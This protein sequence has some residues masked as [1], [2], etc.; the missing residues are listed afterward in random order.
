MSD[1]ETKDQTEADD[2]IEELKRQVAAMEDDVQKSNNE[3]VAIDK[4][5]NVAADGVDE[6][7]M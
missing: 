4:E 5:V 7:S 3:E 6:N 1:S 2:E